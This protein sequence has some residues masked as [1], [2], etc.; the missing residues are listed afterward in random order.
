VVQIFVFFVIFVVMALRGTIVE[1]MKIGTRVW[2]AGKLLLL[3]A[4]LAATYF[5]FAAVAMRVALRAREVQVPDLRGRTLGEATQALAEVG[6]TLRVDENQRPDPK[7]PQGRVTQQDPLPGVQARRQRTIRAWL[8]AGMRAA[9]TPAL[10]GQTERT[11]RI[12][13]EQDGLGIQSVS[14]FRSADYPPDAVVA[15]HPPASSRGASV[16]LLVNRGEQATTFVMP[17]LIGMNGDRAAD[18]LRTRGFRV[19]IVGQQLYPGVPPGTVVRQQPA[20]GFQ[21]GPFDAISLEVSR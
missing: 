15:Q 20:G 18:V 11:A 17:D 14:E 4:A 12:R 1:Q 8:S 21:V 2:S 9:A 10:V 7:V 5:S 3:V 13:L 6:L 16:S 19:S